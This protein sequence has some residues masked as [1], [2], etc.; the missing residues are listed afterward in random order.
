MAQDEISLDGPAMCSR[1]RIQVYVGH[2]PGLLFGAL[3][4]KGD[5]FNI[6]LLGR[7]LGKDAVGQFPGLT[8][9]RLTC[10]KPLTSVCVAAPPQIAVSPAGHLF[11]DRFVTVGGSSAVDAPLQGWAHLGLFDRPP[12]G[13]VHD[14]PGDIS[15]GRFHHGYGP[16]CRGMAFDNRI[17]Q[18]LFWLWEH[19]RLLPGWEQ[20]LAQV[21]LGE[22]R[23][24][25]RAPWR[26]P[27]V[28][29]GAHRRQ[30]LPP[31]RP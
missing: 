4:P 10:P 27:G 31:H 22:Q 13:L 18:G 11:A 20:T 23:A 19:S 21:L 15:A 5:M 28:V 9:G 29:G 12:G 7:G 24:G 26:P 8:H 3:I 6:S 25:A 17:G 2:E 30:P 16:L 1:Q 14:P